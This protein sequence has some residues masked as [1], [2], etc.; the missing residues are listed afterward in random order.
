MRTLPIETG[1]VV[2]VLG[3][4]STGKTTLVRGLREAYDGPA[5]RV[6]VVDE[7]LRAFCDLHG[8]TPHRQEQA[9]IA[10]E[11][12]RRIAGAA[13]VHDL[14]F[15][16]TTALMTAVYSELVF[17]DAALRN[18]AAR[19]HSACD[20]TLLTALDIAWQPD[21]VQRDGPAVRQPVD[22]LIRAA[23]TRSAT[24]FAVIAGSGGARLAAAI[25][26]VDRA[27]ARSLLPAASSAAAS[28][29]SSSAIE[30]PAP[31]GSWRCHCER[32][33]DPAAE[34]RGLRCR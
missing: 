21:G 6:A 20:L 23:L 14:V 33:S 31:A 29:A 34:R 11:Q 13:R 25:A 5:R 32:C 2:A 30:Q 12:T 27:L 19:D 8:R 3:A 16:D 22:R 7:Y 17:D 1:F 15:A 4:E 10:A 24:G 18:S 9:A 28:P 26:S